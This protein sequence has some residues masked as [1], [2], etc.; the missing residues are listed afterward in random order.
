[1]LSSWRKANQPVEQSRHL[2]EPLTS[3]S[4]SSKIKG[5]YYYTNRISH[6]IYY[7]L[8]CL[9]LVHFKKHI[10]HFQ[11]NMGEYSL[12]LD[13]HYPPSPFSA[14]NTSPHRKIINRWVGWER[15]PVRAARHL[16]KQA[17]LLWFPG[18]RGRG[19]VSAW[20]SQSLSR[21]RKTCQKLPLPVTFIPQHTGS[22]HLL[23]RLSASLDTQTESK[24]TIS[25][26]KL[27]M[28][29]S[30]SVLCAMGCFVTRNPPWLG[31]S[32]LWWIGSHWVILERSDS[33]RLVG[34][35]PCQSIV[36]TNTDY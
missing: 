19:Q 33:P 30:C 2:T 26:V 31:F 1:M 25:A 12:H 4:K 32:C 23:A 22:P 21:T 20:L 36:Q 8:I 17:S 16:S 18:W 27:S 3:K 24:T 15:L 11:W 29:S 10:S 5:L 14:Y 13:L 9:W 6:K 7:S 35:D 34:P 28:R